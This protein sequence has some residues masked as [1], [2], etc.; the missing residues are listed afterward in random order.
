MSKSIHGHKVLDLISEKA[1]TREDVKQQFIQNHGADVRFHTC[2]LEALEFDELF[3]FFI[4]AKKV[5]EIDG[6]YILNAVNKC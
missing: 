6:K 4:Q 3:D 2:Q 5:S 1:H